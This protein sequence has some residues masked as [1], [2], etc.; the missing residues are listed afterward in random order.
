[1]ALTLGG[2]PAPR[3]LLTGEEGW[4]TVQLQGR[5]LSVPQTVRLLKQAGMGD[6][7]RIQAG[8]KGSYADVRPDE[9]GG[10]PGV[11][12]DVSVAPAQTVE[13]APQFDRADKRSGRPRRRP[14]SG[15]RRSTRYNR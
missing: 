5:P 12:E 3:S 1:M 4:T 11:L 14:D 6:L 9:V 8:L 13:A 7:G 2:A 15:N 10:L